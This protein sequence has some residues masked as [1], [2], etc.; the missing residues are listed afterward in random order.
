MQSEAE[1]AGFRCLKQIVGVLAALEPVVPPEADFLEVGV[2]G[3]FF[4]VRLWETDLQ[5]PAISTSARELCAAS[6]AH[7]VQMHRLDVFRV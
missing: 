5:G 4:E 1:S 6:T 3:L 7:H 2:F